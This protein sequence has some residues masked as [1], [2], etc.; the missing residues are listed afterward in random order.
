MGVPF[1]NLV[2]GLPWVIVAQPEADCAAG[3]VWLAADPACF[4]KRNALPIK[5]NQVLHGLPPPV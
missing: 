2:Y 1:D 3:E 4:L 5:E